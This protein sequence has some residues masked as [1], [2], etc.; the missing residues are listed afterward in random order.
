M[1]VTLLHH[2]IGMMRTQYPMTLNIQL[3]ADPIL[4][5]KR[6]NPT[7]LKKEEIK[8]SADFKSKVTTQCFFIS[9]I[10]WE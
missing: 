2:D 5:M 1:D 8:V 9:W 3:S 4:S 7:A 10:Y 6:F